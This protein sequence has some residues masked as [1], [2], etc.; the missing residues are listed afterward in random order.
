[1]CARYCD[2]KMLYA[3]NITKL[4]LFFPKNVLKYLL[5]MRKC[6]LFYIFMFFNQLPFNSHL[7][8]LFTDEQIPLKGL[9]NFKF[10]RKVKNSALI[11]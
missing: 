7:I 5:R 3:E 6:E 11:L 1:M 9:W 8:V 2:F 10:C 4:K